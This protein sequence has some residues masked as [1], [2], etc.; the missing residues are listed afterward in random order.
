VTAAAQGRNRPIPGVAT[1]T[2]THVDGQQNAHFHVRPITRKHQRSDTAFQMAARERARLFIRERTLCCT[3]GPALRNIPKSHLIG[4]NHSLIIANMLRLR[5]DLRCHP[6]NAVETASRTLPRCRRKLRLEGC[7]LVC[8]ARVPDAGN[9]VRPLIEM[10]GT[11]KDEARNWIERLFESILWNSR[12]LTLVAVVASLIAAIVMFFVAASDVLGLFSL[13]RQYS[14]NVL[15]VPEHLAM[16]ARIVASVAQSVDG[17]LFALVLIIFALGIYEL[18]IGHFISHIEAGEERELAQRLL[19][20]RSL[21]DL[22][23]KLA[24]II[25][26]ILIVRYF[27]YA[28]DTN[29]STPS[30]LLSL[31]AGIVFIAIAIWF[32]TR[33]EAP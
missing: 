10:K 3:A 24:K 21:D 12:F 6:V 1:P 2:G 31:A 15:N 14:N 22:K 19:V 28:L 16:R 33:K 32:T 7:G 18:F 20:V 5:I 30:E 9:T 23:E 13:A 26:L 29:I 27:E 4:S 17:F 11:V 25:F 8:A